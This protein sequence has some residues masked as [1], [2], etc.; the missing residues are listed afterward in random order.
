[1]IREYLRSLESA[2]AT[3][4]WIAGVDVKRCDVLETP[5][6]SIL[7]Y[8]FRVRLTD[9]SM[10]EMMERV[11]FGGEPASMI[12]TTYCFHWQDREGRLKR[13]WDNAPHF[14]RLSGFPHHIH[15]GNTTEEVISGESID[16]LRVLEYIGRLFGTSL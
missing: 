2:L 11:V 7:V 1:M 10:L 15:S 6:E 16:G 4:P 9:S 13:R 5:C 3:S 12:T 14:P 8:R